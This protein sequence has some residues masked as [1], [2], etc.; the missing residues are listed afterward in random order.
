MTRLQNKIM[1]SKRKR[2]EIKQ[3]LRRYRYRKKRIRLLWMTVSK[4]SCIS[5]KFAARYY[6]MY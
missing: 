4:V 3:R 6:V 5:Y 1:D 2:L